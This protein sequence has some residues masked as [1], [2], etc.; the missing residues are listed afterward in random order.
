VPEEIVV[1]GQNEE[2]LVEHMAFYGER[3]QVHRAADLAR[4]DR[5]GAFYSDQELATLKLPG[6]SALE[7]VKPLDGE[8]DGD[9]PPVNLHDLDD[10]ELGD[11]LTATGAFDGERKPT[12]DDVQQEVGDDAELAG[13]VL[14]VE[15]RTQ[16]RTTL[17]ESL[18]KVAQA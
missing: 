16:D 10:E 18:E 12:V 6:V 5:H 13:R 17:V 1:D 11:W 4:G 9:S 2:R 14:A 3:I 7:I 15:R 8:G